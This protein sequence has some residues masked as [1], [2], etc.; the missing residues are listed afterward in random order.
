MSTH[1]AVAGSTFRCSPVEG[2]HKGLLH[3]TGLQGDCLVDLEI[4]MSVE[5]MGRLK[6][7]ITAT[8]GRLG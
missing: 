8:L 6:D 3:V 4:T 5:A 1:Q 7:D 2:E